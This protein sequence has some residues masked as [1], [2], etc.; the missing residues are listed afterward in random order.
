MKICITKTISKAAV[1]CCH[2][3]LSGIFLKN[4][5]GLRTS[6][7]DIEHKNVVLTHDR[8]NIFFGG[9]GVSG[10]GDP[11]WEGKL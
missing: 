11:S 8:L 10:G 2:S 1:N 7:N 4:P 5:E 6:R 3:R 9:E